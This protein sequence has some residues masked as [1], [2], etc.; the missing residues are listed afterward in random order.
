MRQAFTRWMGNPTNANV[1]QSLANPMVNHE[2]KV[3]LQAMM[4]KR[5]HG[6]ATEG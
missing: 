3:R 6:Q 2:L 4:N 5:E 1:L